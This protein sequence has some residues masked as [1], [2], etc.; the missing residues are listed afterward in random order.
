MVGARG[1]MARLERGE[2]RMHSFAPPDKRRPVVILTR[3]HS[4]PHL[5]TVT[6]AAITSTVRG[7]A[8]EVFLDERDG[9]KG[10]CAVNLHHLTTVQRHNL[11]PRVAFLSADKMAEICA[12]LGYAM[13]C[14]N[15]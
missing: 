1:G 15:A 5:G 11:G 8:S 6:V 13:G 7:V 14:G 12:A 3:P 2:V 9:L 4:I 10:P